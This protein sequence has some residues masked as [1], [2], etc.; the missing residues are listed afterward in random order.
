MEA[1]MDFEK[2]KQDA[3]SSEVRFI[4]IFLIIKDTKDTK[5]IQIANLTISIL[6]NKI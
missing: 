4:Y 5:F 2:K 1:I 3:T 6:L